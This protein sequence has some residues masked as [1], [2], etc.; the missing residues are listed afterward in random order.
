MSPQPQS[1]SLLGICSICH[2]TF[3][4]T[5]S[6]G[7]RSHGPL[8]NCCQGSGKSPSV[9]SRAP[10]PRT[11]TR[12]VK[13]DQQQPVMPSVGPPGQ[14]VSSGILK[15]VPRGARDLAAREIENVVTGNDPL[16]WKRLLHFSSRCLKS[17]QR[18]GIR[19]SLAAAVNRQIREES[20]APG[21]DPPTV[22]SGCHQKRGRES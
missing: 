10:C 5:R 21:P 20:T 12:S 4:M 19:W 3:L 7:V 18:E 14:T 16:T 11:A 6:G 17:P 8:H 9:S 1:D 2:L 13:N 22:C 15:R